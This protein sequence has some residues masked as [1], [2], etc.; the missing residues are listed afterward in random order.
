MSEGRFRYLDHMTD[1]I[2]E[3]YGATLDEAFENSALGLVE[4]MFDF[5]EAMTNNNNNNNNNFSSRSSAV[6][7][8]EIQIKAQGFDLQNLLYDWLEKV[9]LV[10]LMDHVILF[11][12]KVK[13]SKKNSDDYHYLLLGTAK[14]ENQNLEKYHYKVEVKAITYHEME[15]IEER[16]KNRVTIRFLLDL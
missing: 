12:F 11:D 6:D 5:T 1:A 8:K 13:I 10:I 9:M 3:A 14:A 2:I 7:K 15:I 4:T 16:D